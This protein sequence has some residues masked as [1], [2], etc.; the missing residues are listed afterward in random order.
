MECPEG[1]QP[2]PTEILALEAVRAAWTDRKGF[3]TKAWAERNPNVAVV[4]FIL[5]GIEYHIPVAWS[6][7]GRHVGFWVLEAP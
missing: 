3:R 5:G 4:P 6:R 7:N 1:I 2:F